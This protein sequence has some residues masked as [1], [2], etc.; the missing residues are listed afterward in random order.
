MDPHQLVIRHARDWARQRSRALDEDLLAEALQL[1][2]HHDDLAAQEWPQGSAERLFL[3]LWPA[4]GPAPR[5]QDL[6]DTLDTFWRF[7]RATGRM[8]SASAEPGAL[9][10]ESKRAVPKMQEAYNDPSR[11]SQHRV[12]AAFGR[13]AGVDLDS[14]ADIDE[15]NAR[16]EQVTQAWN[17]LPQEERVRLMPDPTPKG[18]KGAQLTEQFAGSSPV[19]SPSPQAVAAAAEDARSAGFVLD[20]LRLVE[21]VGEGR[22]ATQAGLLRPAVAREVPVPRPVAVG[23]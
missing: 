18:T 22:E 12:L 21:W 6:H 13:T 2:S 10:K 17:S 14:A 5:P 20:C 11:H 4:Y 7:L 8:S 3:V 23:A 16:L 1:R 9:R 15:L 19:A